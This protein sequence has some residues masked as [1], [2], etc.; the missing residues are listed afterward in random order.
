MGP[1]AGKKSSLLD[2]VSLGS[3]DVAGDWIE[4]DITLAVQNAMRENRSVDLILGIID[5]GSGNN[6]D[7][8]F[9]PNSANSANRPEISFVYVPGSDALPSDPTP[10]SPLNGSW[11]IEQGINPAPNQN[12]QLSWSYTANNASVGGWSVELDTTPTFD[13]SDLI[14]ATSW[15]NGGFDIIN[16]TYNVSTSLDK[17][18]TWYWRVRA[19]SLTNQIGNWSDS[20]HFLLPDMTTWSIDSNTAAVELRHR[21]GMPALNLPNFIDTWVADSGVGATSSQASSSFFKVGTSN[22]GEN[23]TGLIKIPLTDLPNP[24]SAHISNA[25]LNLYAQFGSSNDNAISI[26][27]ALVPWNASANGTTYDGQN[28]WSAPGAMGSADK[29]MM[30]DIQQGSSAAWMSFD[31]TELVQEA[32]ASG[33]SH[34]SLMVVGSIGEGQTTFTS[35]DGN[36]N[37]KPWL[38]LTWSTG[39]ASIPEVAGT[40][41]QPTQNEI[42]W[43][44]TTHALL[45]QTSNSFVWSHPNQGN[46]DDWRIYIWNDHSDKRRLGYV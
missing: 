11:S 30:S 24:Q 8:L 7:V 46:V 36:T 15:N 31:V 6:R 33:Q 29:G 45:P 27:P 1:K 10:V 42:T 21:E 5:A 17:G 22:S 19:T 3:S 39:N 41:S 14:M 43:D 20:F 28:N 4:W 32:F 44:T 9:F 35:T 40:N 34:L 25:V 16:Q 2:T 37:E 38:N 13:S 23:A 26:H 18:E 12:P